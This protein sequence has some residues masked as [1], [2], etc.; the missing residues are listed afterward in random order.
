MLS[1]PDIQSGPGRNELVGPRHGTRDHAGRVRS[2]R[3][4]RSNSHG[5]G[6]EWHPQS[7]SFP[8]QT[9]VFFKVYVIFQ[10]GPSGIS[11]LSLS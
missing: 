10:C 5:I 2:L 4:R 3:D 6:V 8:L 11:W 1:S 9:S 7:D